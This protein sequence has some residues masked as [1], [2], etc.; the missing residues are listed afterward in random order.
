MNRSIIQILCVDDD[1]DSCE[2]IDHLL[3]YKEN[4]CVLTPV[5]SPV[6]V[7]NLIKNRSFNLYIFDYLLP[8]MSGVELCRNIRLVDA[9]TP[10]VFFTAKAYPDDRENAIRAGATAYLIKPN[11]LVKFKQTINGL[12]AR[13]LSPEDKFN[14][15]QNVS[16]PLTTSG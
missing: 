11:D 14:Y 12:L 4:G 13:R 7:L 1:T 6:E 2:L 16:L 9:E 10:I 5:A 15:S 3:T 8:E